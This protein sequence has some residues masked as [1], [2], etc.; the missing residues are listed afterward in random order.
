MRSNPAMIVNGLG[1]FVR[2]LPARCLFVIQNCTTFRYF[3]RKL[4]LVDFRRVRTIRQQE[5]L[6]CHGTWCTFYLQLH[7]WFR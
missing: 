6:E 5:R 1:R 3:W 2:L 7:Y 4:M